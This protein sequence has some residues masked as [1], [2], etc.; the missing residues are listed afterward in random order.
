MLREEIK[1]MIPNYL[2]HCKTIDGRYKVLSKLGEGRYGKV[3][4][5]FDLQFETLVALKTLLISNI[6]SN[7]KNFFNEVLT[8]AKISSFD[9]SLRIPKILD[10]NLNGLDD[11]GK[12]SVYYV[13]EFIEMGELNAVLEPNDFISEKLACFFFRQICDNL[14]I[15]HSNNLLHLDLKPENIL[16]DANGNLYLCDFGSSTFLIRGDSLK[17]SGIEFGTKIEGIPS[18]ECLKLSTDSNSSKRKKIANKANR[19]L[20]KKNFK[21]SCMNFSNKDFDHFIRHTKFMTTPGYAAPEMTDFEEFQNLAKTDKN[22]NSENDAPNLSKLDVFSLGVILFYV[23]MKSQPFQCASLSDVYYKRLNGDKESFW[24]IF[25]KLRTVSK[26]FKDIVIDALQMTNKN[27]LDLLSIYQHNWMIKHF[28]TDDHFNK[29]HMNINS[30]KRTNTYNYDK[31][32]PGYTLASHFG[33]E[34]RLDDEQVSS[35]NSMM[36][37]NQSE[38]KLANDIH[39]GQELSNLINSRKAKI[40]E[41]IEADL[42]LKEQQHKAKSSKSKYNF[43]LMST[44][45]FVTEFIQKHSHKILLLKK[46]ISSDSQE[47][48]ESVLSSSSDEGSSGGEGR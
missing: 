13:M 44:I 6:H 2:N 10:F 33:P 43:K 40:L 35:K 21:D 46:H 37:V 41:K 48:L 8:L 31:N 34:G 29:T 23:V 15:L 16:M 14:L 24:K 22:L 45:P 17:S 36:M 26:E 3:Y 1:Q 42:K 18:N 27:R 7:L 47:S 4:L 32:S 9:S 28:P 5:C 12:L 39:L 25:A 19:K 20:Q 30:L 38:Q 11:Q